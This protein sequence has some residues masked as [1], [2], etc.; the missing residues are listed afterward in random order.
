[1]K[2]SKKKEQDTTFS[3]L[4]KFKLVHILHKHGNISVRQVLALFMPL[5]PSNGCKISIITLLV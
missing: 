5:N 3:F 2:W 4:L 1:M